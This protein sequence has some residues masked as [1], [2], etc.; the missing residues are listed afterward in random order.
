NQ[1]VNSFAELTGYI[2]TKRP[3]DVVKVF[4]IRNK[5]EM[6]LEV[7]LTKM[8]LAP[9]EFFG[10]EVENLSAQDKQKFGTNHGVKITDSKEYNEVKGKVILSINGIKV[11]D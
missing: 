4:V 2:S 8:E 3:D 1:Q 5:K 10:M 6:E 11:K 9:L 7:A